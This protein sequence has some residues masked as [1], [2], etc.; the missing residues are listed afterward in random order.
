MDDVGKYKMHIKTNN[1][2]NK[3]ILKTNWKA[4]CNKL[5]GIPQQIEK[6]L[7]PNCDSNHNKIEG[8]LQQF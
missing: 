6:D 4:C 2:S 5:K 8:L 1:G 3:K 7:F